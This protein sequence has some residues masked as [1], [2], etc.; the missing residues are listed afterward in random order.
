MELP[1]CESSH[2]TDEMNGRV[3]RGDLCDN[4]LSCSFS[5]NFKHHHAM[6]LVTDIEISA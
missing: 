1:G 3:L 6:T 4:D 2:S 5:A